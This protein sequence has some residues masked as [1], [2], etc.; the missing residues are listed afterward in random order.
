M[1]DWFVYMLRCAD[2]TFYT[3]VTTNLVRRVA[4]HN[5]KGGRGAK[6][7]HIRRPVEL[8]YQE[9][10]TNRSSAQIREAELRQNSRAEKQLLLTKNI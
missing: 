6:Y 4:E 8:V 7:T 2:G 9:T 10:A 3:G 1:S 5:G